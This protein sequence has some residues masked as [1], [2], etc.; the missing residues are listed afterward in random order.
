MGDVSGR[1]MQ[2]GPS[3]GSGDYS[4]GVMAT[5]KKWSEL[6]DRSRRLITVLG[7]IEGVLLVATL[8]DIRR[9]P[10]DQIKGSKRMWTA[11]AFVNIIGPIAYFAFGRR[12]GESA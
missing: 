7:V 3:G 1:P 5:R 9:R 10:A 6:S 4:E 11:L 2:E 12:R 8:V